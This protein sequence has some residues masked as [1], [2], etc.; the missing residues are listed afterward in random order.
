MA[1]RPSGTPAAAGNTAAG[2]AVSSPLGDTG[3]A[4]SVPPG[5]SDGDSIMMLPGLLRRQPVSTL[6]P[7]DAT[8]LPCSSLC[9]EPEEES[10]SPDDGLIARDGCG[11]AKGDVSGDTSR[12]YR[13][14]SPATRA[15]NASGVASIIA[16]ESVEEL[17]CKSAPK[18]NMAVLRA[19]VAE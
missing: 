3:R 5:G 15:S 1:V 6:L 4:R 9:S 8:F 18:N 12:E 2:A 19:S 7:G 16:V 13:P 10:D 14:E 11:D 17:R